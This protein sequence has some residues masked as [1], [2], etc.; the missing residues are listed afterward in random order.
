MGWLMMHSTTQ[1]VKGTSFI[2]IFVFLILFI[3]FFT[4][5]TILANSPDQY[6]TITINRGETLW[7]IAKTYKN[8]THGFN[9]NEFINWVVRENDIDNDRLKS[10]QKIIIP[11]LKQ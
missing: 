9:T 10:N 8:D 7:S 3:S 11:V 6:K 2:I 1:N 5:R 4:A